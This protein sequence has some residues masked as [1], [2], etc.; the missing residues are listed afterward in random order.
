MEKILD[1]INKPDDLKKLNLLEKNKLAE[2]IREYILEVVSKNG[3]H[4]ASNLGVVELTIAL[5]SVFD[6]P[7]D[8]I[9]WDVGHQ[10]Y[11]HKI[12]TGRKEQ[13][14]TLRKF[15]GISRIS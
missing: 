15:G 12:L 6:L 9:V 4:L 11:V 2:E 1:R 13:M 8:K 7:Q 14:Q 5:H 10:S 3:G